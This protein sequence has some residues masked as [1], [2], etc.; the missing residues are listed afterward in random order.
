VCSIPVKVFPESAAHA[1]EGD[2]IDAAVGER[3]AET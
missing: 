3:K 2:R 1:V